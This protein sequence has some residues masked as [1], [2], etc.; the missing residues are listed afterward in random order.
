MSGLFRLGQGSWGNWRGWLF[1]SVMIALLVGM[2]YLLLPQHAEMFMISAM[3][4]A[5]IMVIAG[6]LVC[7]GRAWRWS[8]LVKERG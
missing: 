6:I 7:R 5:W 1:L 2:D 4:W 3:S 8:D